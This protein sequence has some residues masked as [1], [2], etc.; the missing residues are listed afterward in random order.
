MFNLVD[1]VFQLP[2]EEKMKYDMGSTGGYFV[3]NAPDRSMW[4]KRERQTTANCTT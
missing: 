3:Y 2:Y 1:S 4:T